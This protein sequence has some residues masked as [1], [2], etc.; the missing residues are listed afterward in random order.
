MDRAV[1]TGLLSALQRATS[2]TVTRRVSPTGGLSEEGLLFYL[3]ALKTLLPL[4][5]VSE[6]H[7]RPEVGSDSE[8]DDDGI[9]SSHMQVTHLTERDC[10][11]LVVH[12]ERDR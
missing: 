8:E 7:S 10:R 3:G 9:L 2:V 4:L 11:R 6:S 5:P 1:G 12:L